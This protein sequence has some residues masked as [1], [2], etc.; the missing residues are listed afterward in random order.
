M[1]HFDYRDG[2][3]H[4]EEVDLA[5]LADDVGTP[6]Y[7]YSTATLRRHARVIAAAFEGQDC[8]I[9]FSVKA[10]SNLAVLATL[11]EEGCGADVVSGGEL[12]RALRAGIPASKIVFSGVGKTA[13]EMELGLREGIHQFNVESAAELRLLS[14]V[15]NGLGQQAPIAIR[16]NPDVAAGGH[17]NISTGKKGDKFGVP[18]TEAEDLYAEAATLPG[19]RVVGVDVHIGSQIGDLVPMRAAFEKVV[20]LAQRLRAAGHDI[21]RIDVGGGLG[22]PYKQ[23]DEPPPPSAYAAMIAEV[24]A[25]LGVQVILEPGRVIAG[26]AGVMLTTALYEKTAPDRSFLIVDAG[27]NDLM[28]PAL[29]GAHHDIRPVK[30]AAP[31]AAEKTY[32]VVGPICESTDKFAAGRDMPAVAPGDRLAFMSAGAYGAVLSSAYNT[33][34]LVPE[35]LV[36][37]DRFDI[38]R[39]RPD[40]EEM[41]QLEQVP[42]WLKRTD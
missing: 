17:P 7:V 9:A 24:S 12:Q 39:R 5:K 3:L 10:N 26:N 28:R 1:H 20:G 2:R 4:C 31:D 23:G 15:A 22:I 32:D 34:P 33:R 27:M 40:L 41:L 30:Q 16:V 21:A 42:D 25:G 35:V 18:W 6:C 8:L 29:Y 38:V 19:I 14:Y 36:N 13:R 37:G 11:A